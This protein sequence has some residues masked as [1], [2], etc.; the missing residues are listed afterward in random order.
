MLNH[1]STNTN[2]NWNQDDILKREARGPYGIV[3]FEVQEVTD[4]YIITEKGS[5]GDKERYYFPKH[6]V[7]Y[8]DGATLY[9][10]L[11]EEEAIQYKKAS[12]KYL[13]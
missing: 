7:D 8:F 1:F 5:V 6:L 10:K 11:T 4:E 9:L 2:S 12:L 3:D 13:K